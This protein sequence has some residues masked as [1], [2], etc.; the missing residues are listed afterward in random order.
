MRD[1]LDD[2]ESATTSREDLD[3]DLDKRRKVRDYNEE[4]C[5]YWI[6]IIGAVIVAILAISL[7]FVHLWHLIAPVDWRWVPV[8]DLDKLE[9]LS[10][11]VLAGVASSL[12]ITYF[13]KR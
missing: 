3:G 2:P 6:R 1:P 8:A 12:S 9:R 4:N 11:T 7:I 13:F 5:F 10:A